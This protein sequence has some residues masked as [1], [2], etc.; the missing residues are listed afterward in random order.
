MALWP[1]QHPIKWIPGG[2]V[3]RTS[4]LYLGGVDRE[5]YT[6]FYVVTVRDLG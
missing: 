2:K 4:I 5:K 6:F 3:A 1:N